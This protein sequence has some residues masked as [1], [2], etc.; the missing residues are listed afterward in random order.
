[1]RKRRPELTQYRRLSNRFAMFQTIAVTGHIQYFAVVNKTVEYS[2]RNRTGNSAHSSK[3]L[4]DVIII[5]VRSGMAE[6]NPKKRF[7]SAGDNDIK[8]SSSTTTN[9]ARLR[10]LR[11]RLLVAEVSTVLRI[12]IRLSSVSNATAYPISNPLTAR[13]IAR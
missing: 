2:G 10:Y 12:F 11:R 4:I 13:A 8:P 7:A 5:D 9:A 6:T 3:P 1:M